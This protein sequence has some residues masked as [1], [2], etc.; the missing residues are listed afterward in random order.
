M[1][2]DFLP[3]SRLFTA[4]ESDMTGNSKNITIQY[5]TEKKDLSPFPFCLLVDCQIM[6]EREHYSLQLKWELHASLK[7][8]EMEA[9][10]DS[11]NNRHSYFSTP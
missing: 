5:R 6:G 11:S 7:G 1:Q 2:K 4:L 9:D 3:D 10:K 8:N